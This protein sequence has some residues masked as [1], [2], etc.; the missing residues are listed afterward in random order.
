[1]IPYRVDVPAPRNYCAWSSDKYQRASCLKNQVT[2]YQMVTDSILAKIAMCVTCLAYWREL[3]H[4]Y[5]LFFTHIDTATS[6]WMIAH[7]I[8]IYTSY[9]LIPKAITSFCNTG[10]LCK[11]W[12]ESKVDSEGIW[13]ASVWTSLEEQLY[14]QILTSELMKLQFHS[15]LQ[16]SWH[17]QRKWQHTV[18]TSSRN[19]FS[20]VRLPPLQLSLHWR[21]QSSFLKSLAWFSTKSHSFQMCLHNPPIA[22]YWLDRFGFGWWCIHLLLA[23]ICW[24]VCT[25]HVNVFTMIWVKQYQF[26]SCL[27]L[28]GFTGPTLDLLIRVC[29]PCCSSYVLAWEK[30]QENHRM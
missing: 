2:R 30:R 9:T 19:V 18:L 13:V 21:L 27:C 7:C 11:G 14:L 1:M 17:T 20:M 5:H 23:I 8:G 3:K 4:P 16:W 15:R 26:R 29:K 24:E 28:P 12:R 6:C 25:P 22:I 10:A